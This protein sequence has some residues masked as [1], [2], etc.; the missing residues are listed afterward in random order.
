M[1]SE[2]DTATRRY[3]LQ[4]LGA[5]GAAGLAG[6]SGSDNSTSSPDSSSGGSDPEPEA[7]S[8]P[9]EDEEPDYS[10]PESEHADITEMATN[11]M[12]LGDDNGQ[13]LQAVAYSP[14][15][16]AENYDKA[17]VDNLERYDVSTYSPFE[18]SKTDVPESFVQ[19]AGTPWNSH[20]KVDQF[21]DNVTEDDLAS[22]LQDAGFEKVDEGGDFEVYTDGTTPHA[23][24]EERHVVVL[25]GQTASGGETEIL[26]S[27]VI[28]E[29]NQ[30]RYDVPDIIRDGIE[31]LEVEDSLTVQNTLAGGMEYMPSTESGSLQPEYGLASV[32]FEDGIKFGAWPFK[33]ESTAEQAANV[34]SNLE[35]EL[36]DGYENVG[37]QGRVVTA[38]GGNYEIQEMNEGYFTA[39]SDPRI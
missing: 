37:R 5:V 28:K 17:F 16:L 7:D 30:D 24:G 3:V 1:S 18:F 39:I 11:W 20:Y 33:S 21:P 35:G 31:A 15:K 25:P 14:S 8:E 23:V 29:N 9:V 32:D 19:K 10:L 13:D 26:M 12:I 38:S 36:R 2:G 34:L 4:T 6:C 22:Q 27:R